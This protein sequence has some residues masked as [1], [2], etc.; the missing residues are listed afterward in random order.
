VNGPLDLTHMK[1]GNLGTG[2]VGRTLAAALAS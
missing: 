1:I 2:V